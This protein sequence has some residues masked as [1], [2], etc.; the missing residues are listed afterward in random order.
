MTKF[1][2][3]TALI[4]V[5]LAAATLAVL[6]FP[7]ANAAAQLAV[8][9]G[10][11]S[12][13][14]AFL[15][16]NCAACHTPVKGVE[17]KNCIVC[18]AD[19]LA[20]LQREP[21]AFHANI[22]SC[23]ECHLEHRGRTPSTIKMDHVALAQIGLKQLDTTPLSDDPAR[24]ALIAW[25]KQG[26]APASASQPQPAES[27]INSTVSASTASPHLQRSESL[28]NCAE[29]HST[30]DRHVG[31]FGTDCA[32]CHATYKWTIPEFR[33]PSTASQSCAQCHQAP[34]SHYMGH[35]NMISMTVA[36]QPH[37]QVSQCFLC[38]QTTAWNDIKRVGYYKHH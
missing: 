4:I 19:N 37:A 14:H 23:N 35:F 17:A 36:G 9:P 1:I 26:D 3:T 8:I 31:L 33:H 21:T 12:Q 13:S 7:K 10:K 29:C 34:P 5:G 32:S 38:H 28:L 18:H 6:H 25:L 22:G 15:E 24:T 16:N 20:I 27:L 30:K 2:L 11:L